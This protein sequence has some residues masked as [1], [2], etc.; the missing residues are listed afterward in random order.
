MEKYYFISADIVTGMV[1]FI[2]FILC[3]L[4]VHIFKHLK[5][6]FKALALYII[7]CFLFDIT[8]TVLIHFK[9]P[10]IG[11]L[12]LFNMVELLLLLFFLHPST[13]YSRTIKVFIA[14]G[15]LINSYEMSYYLVSND[16]IINKGRMFNA[17][18]F[19]GMLLY[20]L[21]KDTKDIKSLLLIHIMI[22]Y[23]SICFIQFLLLNFLVHIPH[24]SIFVTWILYAIAGG[25][26]Y[27]ISTFY[28]WKN[29]NILNT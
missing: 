5:R 3:L 17:L 12:P 24:D 2:S 13:K 16:S 21:T 20:A 23:F 8:N 15:V 28:L 7:A 27:V 10:N 25:V 19:L 4:N 18:I 26:F 11:L 29:T 22:M 6:H 9:Y 1:T 14:I